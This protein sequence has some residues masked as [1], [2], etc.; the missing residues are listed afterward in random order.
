MNPTSENTR[1]RG[2]SVTVQLVSNQTGMNLTKQE[3]MLVFVSTEVIESTLVK[4]DTSSTAILPLNCECSLPTFKENQYLQNH[5]N[6]NWGHPTIEKTKSL[7]ITFPNILC[8]VAISGDLLDF[9]QLLKA[10]G[11]N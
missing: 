11:N 4:L 10:F 5:V 2:G 6:C 1:S 9:G 8:N 3:H 7:V